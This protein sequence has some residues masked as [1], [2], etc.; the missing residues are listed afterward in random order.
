[1]NSK[2]KPATGNGNGGS[3]DLPWLGLEF[4]DVNNAA[5]LKV[6]MASS[7]LRGKV[8]RWSYGLVR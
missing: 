7:D 3:Q 4:I 8:V 2:T 1:M 6:L 5:L